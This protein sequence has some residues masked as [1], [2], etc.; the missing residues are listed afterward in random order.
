MKLKLWMILSCLSVLVLGC[1]RISGDTY[2]IAYPIYF[3]NDEV[4]DW[5]MKN[6]KELLTDVIVHNETHHRVCD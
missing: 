2:D 6:D 3:D 1:E 4:A 5:L